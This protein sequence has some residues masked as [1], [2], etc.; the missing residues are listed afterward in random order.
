MRRWSCAS[1][2]TPSTIATGHPLG[3]E[4]LATSL[5]ERLRELHS[6][7]VERCPLDASFDVLRREVDERRA[8]GQLEVATAGPYAGRPVG[9]L[10]DLVDS[11]M[12]ALPRSEG[13]MIH[14][15]LATE[16]IWFDTTGA[17]TF[18]GWRRGGVGDRHLDLAAAANLLAGLHGPSLVP[19][20]FDAYGLDDVDPLRLDAHQLLAHLLA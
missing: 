6:L 3:P 7:D 16:R 10:V 19:V 12:G 1:P 15:G 5:A 2:T 9:E 20:L 4:H 8:R 14:G 11:L 17:L 18:I 13:V